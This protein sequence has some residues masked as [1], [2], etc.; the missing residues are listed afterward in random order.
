MMCL[1]SLRLRLWRNV[2]VEVH[3]DMDST[4]RATAYEGYWREKGIDAPIMELC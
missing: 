2:A 4:D 1:V 3:D